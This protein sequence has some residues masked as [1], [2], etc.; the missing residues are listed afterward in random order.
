MSEFIDSLYN[1]RM[2]LT[3][4]YA[5]NYL[6]DRQARNLV[7]DPDVAN[8]VLYTQLAHLGFR[9]SGNHIYRP[10]CR[11]C[12]ACRSLRIPVEH[13][14]PNRSQRR[15]L[16]RNQDLQVAVMDATFQDEHFDLFA[17]YVAKRHAKAGMDPAEPEDY[18]SFVNSLWC[19]TKLYEVRCG[20]RLLAIA[21]TDYLDDGLSAVYTFFDPQE[22]VRGLGT[23]AILQQIAEAKRK[24]LQWVYLGY[25][26]ENCDKMVYK[27]RFN[28]HEIYIAEG[29]RWIAMDAVARNKTG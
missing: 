13:F 5:C 23:F 6:S 8:N 3:T 26:I 22:H 16:M 2:F 27:K 7:A 24:G 20:Q 10:H 14:R 4:D 12:K 19:S 1:L 15:V 28:P 17:H 11:G 18:W 21:V 9:R 29:W 25:W